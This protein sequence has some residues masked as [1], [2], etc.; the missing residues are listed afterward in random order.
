[1]KSSCGARAVLENIERANNKL[2]NTDS[3][4][5]PQTR[6]YPGTVCADFLLMRLSTP[7]VKPCASALGIEAAFVIWGLGRGAIPLICSQINVKI[8]T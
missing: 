4:R 2:L 7:R 8:A 6:A 5:I 1:M 3:A